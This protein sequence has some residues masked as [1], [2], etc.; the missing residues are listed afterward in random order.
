MQ[1]FLEPMISVSTT[2]H[3][4]AKSV[5][6]SQRE[7]NIYRKWDITDKQINLSLNTGY[8]IRIQPH[9]EIVLK[10]MSDLNVW[11]VFYEFYDNWKTN[12]FFGRMLMWE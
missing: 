6:I 12:V 3:E 2:G 9:E 11:R 1:E 4:Y 5:N 10:R 7:Q 8:Q